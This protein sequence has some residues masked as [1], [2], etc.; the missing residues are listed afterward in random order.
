MSN[1][2]EFNWSVNSHKESQSGHHSS[3]EIVTYTSSLNQYGRGG[4]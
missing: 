4:T 3:Q 2:S 1:I